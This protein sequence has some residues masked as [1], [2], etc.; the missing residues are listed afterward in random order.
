MTSTEGDVARVTPSSIA[1]QLRSELDHPIVDVDGHILE[2]TPVLTEYLRETVSSKAADAL[3]ASHA[4]H[5]WTSPWEGSEDVRRRRWISQNNWW[6]WP[7]KN[8]LDRATATLPALYAERMDD[9]GIDYSILYP[10]AGLFLATLPDPDTR[11]EI[12]NGYNRWIRE[13]CR[14]YEEQLTGV[15]IVAMHTPEEAV[16]ELD[17]AVNELG[18]KV[19][20]LQG[21]VSR[22]LEGIGYRLDYFGL[23]SAHDYD[24]VWAKCAELRVAPTFHSGTGLRAGRSISNYVYNHIGS[25]AQAQEGLAKSLFLG[26]VTRRFPTLNFGFL[27]CGAAWACSLFVELVGHFAKRNLAAMEYVDPAHLDVDRVMSYVEEFG[28]AFTTSHLA[29]ARAFYD[30]DYPGLPRRDDFWRAAIVDGREIVDLFVNRFYIGCEADDRSVAWAFDTRTNPYGAKIRAIFGSDLGH[31][32]VT[33]VAGIVP[34]A[35][36]LVEEGLISTGDLKELLFSNPV[37]LHA[38]VNP[39]FFRGSRIENEVAELL[40]SERNGRQETS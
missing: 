22:P 1:R 17:F 29:E 20:C 18:H 34:E 38:G 23:D 5:R 13:L 39:D 27:E 36:E 37:R 4:F 21:H 19:V 2:L 16:R 7:T 12:I 14:P 31:W 11:E 33:D 15:A 9:L 10:S 25:I 26:G 24:P 35:Y 3:V 6:G 30:R 8:T 40:T 28:D 32:D